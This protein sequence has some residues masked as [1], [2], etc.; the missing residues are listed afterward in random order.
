M[1]RMHEAASTT[2]LRA[3]SC[4]HVRTKLVIRVECDPAR[5]PFARIEIGVLAPQCE[6][7]VVGVHRTATLDRRSRPG[8]PAPAELEM[9]EVLR[10]IEEAVGGEADVVAVN[11]IDAGF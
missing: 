2:L 8:Q 6:R 5:F 3:H 4:S 10:P 9:P 1:K 11:R 7:H